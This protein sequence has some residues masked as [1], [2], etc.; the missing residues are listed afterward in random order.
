MKVDRYKSQVLPAGQIPWVGRVL[1]WVKFTRKQLIRGNC[2][3]L[4]GIN[5]LSEGPPDKTFLLEID[6]TLIDGTVRGGGYDDPVPDPLLA[7]LGERF[8][9]G[10]AHI[11]GGV[12]KRRPSLG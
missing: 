6:L 2:V 3:T 10:S 8:Y 5:T 9:T 4:E 11:P 7:R 1:A 12:C